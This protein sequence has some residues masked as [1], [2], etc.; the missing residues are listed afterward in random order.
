[1][2]NGWWSIYYWIDVCVFVV[3]RCFVLM[4]NNLMF[5][6]LIHFFSLMILIFFFLVKSIYNI[7]NLIVF[8]LHLLLIRNLDGFFSCGHFRKNNNNKV[9]TGFFSLFFWVNLQ[10]MQSLGNFHRMHLAFCLKFFFLEAQHW[11][12]QFVVDVCFFSLPLYKQYI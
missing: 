10:L 1:M 3:C 11:R 8:Y 5:L 9:L 6:R 7:Y 2:K 4:M 12:R